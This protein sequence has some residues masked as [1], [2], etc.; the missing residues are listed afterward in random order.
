MYICL[1][2]LS[3]GPSCLLFSV[4]TS[5]CFSVSG[6]FLPSLLRACG[7]TPPLIKLTPVEL[8]IFDHV[9][10]FGTKEVLFS[11]SVRLRCIKTVLSVRIRTLLG[12]CFFS[13][14]PWRNYCSKRV[15]AKGEL[16]CRVADVRFVPFALSAECLHLT[17]NSSPSSRRCVFLSLHLAEDLR[18]S[19]LT[20]EHW[21]TAA[22]A[23]IGAPLH[24][25]CWA[26][27]QIPDWIRI[28]FIPL[29]Q[30]CIYT[31]DSS[32]ASEIS[33][34]SLLGLQGAQYTEL[35][36][37]IVPRKGDQS[38]F[39]L[40]CSWE[41]LHVKYILRIFC[42]MWILLQT[43]AGW[44][45]H[46]CPTQKP[47]T[48]FLLTCV[49]WQVFMLISLAIQSVHWSSPGNKAPGH[50]SFAKHSVWEPLFYQKQCIKLWKKNEGI[51]CDRF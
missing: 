47:S 37:G 33:E 24:S 20:T 21:C 13:P 14:P 31:L 42:G 35:S 16:S 7:S 6:W 43:R 4:I 51:L 2:I 9:D 32:S 27:A 46:T 28:T 30:S 29:H 18:C 34:I 19:A 10:T 23:V 45:S 41:E 49:F 1:Y 15:L 48:T 50:P 3:G 26:A 22:V 39:W 38:S 44:C 12:I 11:L 36:P 8:A 40:T 5:G 17:M 25:A